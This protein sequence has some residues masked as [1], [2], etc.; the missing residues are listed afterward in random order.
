MV[1]KFYPILNIKDLQ[2]KE[3][4]LSCKGNVRY[5]QSS[6]YQQVWYVFPVLLCNTS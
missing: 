6:V 3:K 5:K 1:V 2:Y 4:C